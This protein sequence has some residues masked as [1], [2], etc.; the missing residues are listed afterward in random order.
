[1]PKLK[2]GKKHENNAAAKR[3]QK[4]RR[5]GQYR[6]GDHAPATREEQPPIIFERNTVPTELQGL[7]TKIAACE[8]SANEVGGLHVYL[9]TLYPETDALQAVL[10]EVADL[11]RRTMYLPPDTIIWWSS[12]DIDED[13]QT[14]VSAWVLR[15]NGNGTWHTDTHAST[16]CA[17]RQWSISVVLEAKNSYFEIANR[18]SVV[19]GMRTWQTKAPV[20]VFQGHLVNRGVLRE[21]GSRAIL[22]AEFSLSESTQRT[23]LGM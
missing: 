4:R 15:Y 5:T 23:L 8:R 12:L 18:S 20:V 21:G 17:H 10:D 6:Q 22:A 7:R 16:P 13:C 1:M 9:D 2:R 11:I 19:D 14:H 3:A